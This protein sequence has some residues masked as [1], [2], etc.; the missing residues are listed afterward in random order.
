MEPQAQARSTEPAAAAPAPPPELVRTSSLSPLRPCGISS[1]ASRS[2]RFFN[3]RF[4]A[5]DPE[6]CAAL[7]GVFRA[8][9]ALVESASP[10]IV[11]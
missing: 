9:V 5:A 8:L 2:S 6:V 1:R 11:H 10:R 3:A 7:G 4:A